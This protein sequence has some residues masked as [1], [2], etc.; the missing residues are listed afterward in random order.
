MRTIVTPNKK[1][2]KEGIKQIGKD[3]I[4]KSEEIEKMDL[5]QIASIT[6]HAEIRPD[7]IYNYDITFNKTILL[8]DVEVE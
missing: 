2:L 3:L 8:E 7:T 6:I 4:K 1:N 5:K